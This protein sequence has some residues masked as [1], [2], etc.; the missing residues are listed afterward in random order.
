M[1]GHVTPLAPCATPST[2]STRFADPALVYHRR[3]QVTPSAP[4]VLAPSTSAARFANP[5]LVYHNRERAPPSAPDALSTR[6]ESPMYH[7]VAIHHDPEHVHPMLTRCATGVLHPVNRLILAADTA[8]HSFGCL[9][10]HLCLHRP[11]RPPPASH[12]GGVYGPTGQPHLRPGAASTRHQRGH[13]P[14]ALSPQ[15]DLGRLH[16]PLQGPLG[17]SRLHPAPRI[18]LQQNL[19]PCRQVRHRSSR[20]LPHP[21]PG[22]D[23]NGDFPVGEWLPIPVPAN[24]H[25]GAFSPILVPVGEFILVGKPTGNLSPLEV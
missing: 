2:S 11:R 13:R 6:T 14:V 25:E 23:G 12:Y 18:G 19:Q 4:V 1:R 5:T 8:A 20:P 21:L 15:A 7:P 3:G 22:R 16:R 10:G 9:P 24:A 17:P